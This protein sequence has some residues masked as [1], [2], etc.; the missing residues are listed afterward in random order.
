[1]RKWGPVRWPVETR[2]HHTKGLTKAIVEAGAIPKQAVRDAAHIAVAA[3]ND[4]D[5]LLTWNCRHLANAQIIR[6]VSA[7]CA[8]HGYCMPVICTPEELMGA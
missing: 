2:N 4:V 8:A 6:G 7:V 3:I 1:M 5:Y